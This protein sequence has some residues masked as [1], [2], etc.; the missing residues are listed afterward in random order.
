[1]ACLREL[2]LPTFRE[3]FEELAR[4]ALQET[5]SYE[6]YLLELAQR[7]CQARWAKRTERL[8][9]CIGLSL[10]KHFL[11]VFRRKTEVACRFRLAG[12]WSP[13]STF[14]ELRIQQGKLLF[15]GVHQ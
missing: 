12:T 7:E 11:V 10:G 5:A 6:Q 2:H 14:R 8:L 4:R 9:R 3:C 1:M 15:V 13:L